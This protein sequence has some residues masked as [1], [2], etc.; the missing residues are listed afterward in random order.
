MTASAI[1]HAQRFAPGAA[2]EWTDVNGGTR[3]GVV[4][5]ETGG[6]GDFQIGP[7]GG[8]VRYFALVLRDGA[9]DTEYADKADLRLIAGGAR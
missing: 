1:Q 9:E 3:T 5:P 6:M 2:V 7:P 4:V 8:P